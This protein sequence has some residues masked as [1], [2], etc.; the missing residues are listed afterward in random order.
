MRPRFSACGKLGARLTTFSAARYA[1]RSSTSVFSGCDSN[2]CPEMTVLKRLGFG[3]ILTLCSGA[4]LAQTRENR[5]EAIASALRANEFSRAVDLSRAA[6]K[7]SPNDAE[8]W[9][10]Q[11]TA[12]A[13]EGNKPEALASYSAALKISPDYLPALQGAV[14]IE[15][16]AGNANAIPLLRHVLRLRPRDQTSHGML[17][18]LE[19][20]Q[21]NCADAVVHFKAAGQLFD[22]QPDGLH[23]YAACLVKLKQ[24]DQ[25]AE[26]FQRTVGLKPEDGRERHLLAALQLMAHKPQDALSALQPMLQGSNP[27]VETLELAATAY[28][29][30]K[31]TPQAVATLRQAILLDP[32]NVN[33]YV[34]FANISSAHDSFQ[35]GIDVMS[36]G[37]GQLPNAAP[38]YLARGVL[39]VQLAQYDKAEADFEIAHQ[40][41]P[42]Q[43]LSSAAQGLLA[44]QQ[45][46]LDHALATVQARL[47]H[48]PNDPVLLYLRADFLS[49]KG[50]EPG[51]A[52]FKLAMQSARQAVSLRPGLSGARTV[53]AKLYLQSG[54]YQEAVEQ[55]RKAMDQDPRDQTALYHLIQALRK[56]GAQ[57]EIPQLLQRLAQLRKQTAREE[58][59]RYQ[60]KLVE[61]DTQ[62]K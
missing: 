3:I 61:E 56:T 38:L 6:L 36:D 42:H 50:V 18:V 5:N 53:L 57:H 49:Q 59:E 25:A 15:F 55:C 13:G 29:S 19:Y 54:Q 1:S 40:L 17:A 34:D 12:Y 27:D 35:V 51:T 10:M 32:K 2:D 60:Y 11:G 31:D 47:D 4:S 45:N 39:Y 7:Q 48:K 58:S 44:E 52:E 24:F 8:L 9:A 20:Q 30:S 22:A 14:Q 26:I 16:D 37:I 43:S 23:A 62:P 41:D 28:E 33:L 21:G 46:D